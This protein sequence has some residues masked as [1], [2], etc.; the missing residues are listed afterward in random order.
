[1]CWKQAVTQL[2]CSP[3]H[4]RAW[5][6]LK[7]N[8]QRNITQVRKA[9]TGDANIV[10]NRSVPRRINFQ[11][12]KRKE[13][14]EANKWRCFWFVYLALSWCVTLKSCACHTHTHSF[15]AHPLQPADLQSK[16]HQ[17]R[18]AAHSHTMHVSKH[19]IVKSPI[20]NSRVA[21]QVIKFRYGC[22]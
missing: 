7:H 20:W 21:F 14:I 8:F 1:M 4:L 3:L 9:A 10:F 11:D 17:V 19:N 16:Q 18:D 12:L 5:Q 22:I 6:S 2:F 13:S 15:T